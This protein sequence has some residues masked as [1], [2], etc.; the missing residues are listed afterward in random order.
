MD[1]LAELAREH[2]PRVLGVLT[3]RFGDLDLADDAVQDALVEAVRRWP[4]DGAPPNPPAWLMTVAQRKAVD[5]LRRAASAQRRALAAAPEL[6]ERGEPA[7]A[8]GLVD[9]Q[10]DVPDERLRLILLTC[11]PAL[12]RDTQVALTLRLVAGLTVDEIAAGL[13]VP[14]ATV[15]GRVVRAKRKIRLAGVPLSVPSDL[16]RRLPEVLAVIYLVFN[17]GYLG[18]GPDEAV[19]I[20]LADEAVRLARLLHR[21]LPTETEVAGLLALV[22][23]HRSRFDARL[24]AAGD[25]V[26]LDDQDRTSWDRAA[27]AEADRVL[28][29]AIARMQP[30]VYQLQAL[31]AGRHAHARTAQ[32]T[33]WPTVAALYGHLVAM[34]G[35]PVVRLNQAV[36]VAM[37][38]GAAA[39]L[40]MVEALD[41]LDDYHLWHATRADLLRR[42]GRTADALP[43]YRRA[44]DLTVNPAERRFL[45]ARIRELESL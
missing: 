38:E 18:H 35:S 31:I 7:A 23:Y 24:D 44:A 29:D 3:A 5:H 21:L 4:T 1:A 2:A 42:T 9:E 27:I 14:A 17:A 25:L 36:A 19:R 22:L 32:E 45:A 12:G 28:D 40:A 33:D 39:G 8:R 41:G 20:D 43:A 13:L 30:G 34:T 11:H 6:I 16:T 37:A 26:L 10:N 15:A